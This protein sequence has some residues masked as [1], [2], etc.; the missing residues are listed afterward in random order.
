MAAELGHFKVRQISDHNP[1]KPLDLAI[2]LAFLGS[3]SFPNLWTGYCRINDYR[4][5]LNQCKSS[6][7]DCAEIEAA[8]HFILECPLYEDNH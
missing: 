5:K 6:E 2:S 7:C 4:Y 3:I 1:F 8:Q